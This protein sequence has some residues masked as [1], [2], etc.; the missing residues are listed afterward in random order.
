MTL[1]LVSLVCMAGLVIYGTFQDCDPYLDG[2]LISRD[3]VHMNGLYH[4]HNYGTFEG[5][6]FSQNIK[7]SGHKK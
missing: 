4:I 1:V 5:C 2:K 3:Q 6:H 7:K